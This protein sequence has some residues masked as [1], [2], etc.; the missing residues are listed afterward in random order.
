MPVFN[1]Q[2]S[3]Y[4][5]I[6]NFLGPTQETKCIFAFNIIILGTGEY[7]VKDFDEVNRTGRVC[8]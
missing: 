3:E 5:Q 6:F 4:L 2:I 1:F 8:R 7:T